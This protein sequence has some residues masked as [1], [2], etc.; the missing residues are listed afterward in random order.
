[1][2]NRTLNIAEQRRRM[3]QQRVDAVLAASNMPDALA[4]RV[5]ERTGSTRL[6]A[7]AIA[8]LAAVLAVDPDVGILLTALAA[9]MRKLGAE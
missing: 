1:M 3:H 6:T 5:L 4:I 8:D 9:D 7:E 2:N